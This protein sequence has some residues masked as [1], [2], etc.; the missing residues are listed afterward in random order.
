MRNAREQ[1]DDAVA[2]RMRLDATVSLRDGI[3]GLPNVDDPE[4]PLPTAP[5]LY[6]YCAALYDGD[7]FC[8]A[9]VVAEQVYNAGQQ[10]ER[11]R[12]KGGNHQ[13]NWK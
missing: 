11:S 8:E 3:L 5:R 7:L 9:I 10:Q 13:R 1:T 12:N 4:F 2:A 6:R